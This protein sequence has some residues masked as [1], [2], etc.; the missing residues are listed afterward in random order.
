V[1]AAPATGDLFRGSAEPVIPISLNTNWNLITRTILPVI[2]AESPLAAGGGRS[3]LELL[4]ITEGPGRRLEPGRR[5]PTRCRDSTAHASNIMLDAQ[6]KDLAGTVQTVAT[7]R[8]TAR[9]CDHQRCTAF[10]L[11]F[12]VQRLDDGPMVRDVRIS[13][14]PQLKAR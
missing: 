4:S 13:E 9:P 10:H 2:Y 3:G 12:L 7:G 6:T 1:A 8:R 14:D 5:S 11:M